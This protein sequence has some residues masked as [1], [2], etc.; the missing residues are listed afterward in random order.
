MD[1]PVQRML[2]DICAHTRYCQ[3][4]T[5]REALDP[6][7][8]AA[9]ERVPREAFVPE[10][11]RYLAYEDGPLPIGQG[12]TISQPFIVALMTDLVQPRPD[13]RILEVGTGSGYQAAIL[14]EL[15]AQVYSIEIVPALAARSAHELARL[16]YTNIRCR[17]GDGYAGWPEAAPFDGI[18]VTAAARH[19]PPPMMDQL[20][21]GARLVIPVGERWGPQGLLLVEKDLRG[22]IQVR[23]MLAV[24]F[25]PLTG[26]LA[27]GADRREGGMRLDRK[28]TRL[29]SSHRYISRMP[30]SA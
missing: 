29:N 12:Q 9:M 14:A 24:A 21:P 13:A 18:L 10:H 6:R 5:G 23:E 1:T 28:S 15:V 4:T 7:V 8:M 11:E 25:V 17:A 19:I 2:E 3:G 22:E 20:A 30:S 27:A 26:D 16:G